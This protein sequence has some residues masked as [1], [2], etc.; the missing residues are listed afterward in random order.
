MII[1]QVETKKEIEEFRQME[2]DVSVYFLKYAR[3][4]DI[5]DKKVE[6]Y[7]YKDTE[8]YLS[9]KYKKFVGYEGDNITSMIMIKRKK[10]IYDGKYVTEIVDLYVKPEYRSKGYG[11]ELIDFI[12]NKFNRRIELSCFY[13]A[14]ANEFY[15]KIGLKT[16]EVVYSN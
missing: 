3:N 15:K 1:K 12:K 16:L 5:Y 8:K 13:N 4:I 2:Y 10:S 9:S 14:P 11:K 6:N 7:T